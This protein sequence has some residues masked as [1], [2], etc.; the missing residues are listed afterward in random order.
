MYIFSIL[1]ILSLFNVYLFK[2]LNNL[3]I[4]FQL[5]FLEMLY[6]LQLFYNYRNLSFSVACNSIKFDG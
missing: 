3:N 2:N 4:S 1:Q 6:L 5:K